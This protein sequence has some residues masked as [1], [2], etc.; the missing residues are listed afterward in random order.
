MA[1]ARRLAFGG[2]VVVLL[3][4]LLLGAKSLGPT[5]PKPVSPLNSQSFQPREKGPVLFRHQPHEAAG[6]A[7]TACHHDY[8]RGRNVWRQGQPVAACESCHQ[9][10]P[11]PKMLDLK[12][13]FHRQCKGCHLQSGRQGRPAGPIRCEQC[14]QS[15]PNDLVGS[16]L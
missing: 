10:Q 11:R 4:A 2:L 9:V 13:A 8:V 14:H 7:C 1:Q 3:L 5:T 12:N 6:I 15:L 16:R